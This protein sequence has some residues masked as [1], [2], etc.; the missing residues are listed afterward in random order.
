[1]SKELKRRRYAQR[2]HF[3]RRV[4]ERLGFELS[5]EEITAIKTD[6]QTGILTSMATPVERLEIYRVNIGERSCV[7][8]YDKETREL[9]TFLTNEM[10][11][12]R[13]LSNAPGVTDP[14]ALKTS[15]ADTPAGQV[16]Q[17]LKEK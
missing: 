8:V 14:T 1:M 16:L 15:L 7:V 3:Q 17:G 12:A 4:M 6:I 2:L 11:Q 5:Q 9:A 10:W 13:R